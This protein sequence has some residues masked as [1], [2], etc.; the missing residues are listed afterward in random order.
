MNEYKYMCEITFPKFDKTLDVAI[1]VNKTVYY[2]MV[3]ISQ[4]IN[5]EMSKSFKLTGNEILVD[6]DLF[7]TLDKNVLVKDSG[8]V[9]GS[10]LVFY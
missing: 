4:I 9:N 1:P 10:R 2:V 8:I 5:E 6:K 3:M 7:R